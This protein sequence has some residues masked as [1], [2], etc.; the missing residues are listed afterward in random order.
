MK[1]NIFLAMIAAIVSINGICASYMTMGENDSLRIRPN[2]LNG[3]ST[4][5]VNMYLD[6]YADYFNVGISYPGG[7]RPKMMYNLRGIESGDG[8]A[9]TFTMYDGSEASFMPTLNVGETYQSVSASIS[10]TGWWD[11]NMDGVLEPYGSVKWEPGCH[12][13]VFVFNFWVNDD[14][15]EGYVVLDGV[16]NSGMDSR[17]PILANVQFYKKIW[18]WVG[19]MKG[20]VSGD[21]RV[22]ITDAT[23]LINSLQDAGDSIDDLDEFQLAAADINGDGIVNVTDVTELINILNN[24]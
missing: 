24:D 7:L 16:F 1:K 6:A 9:V 8:L 11:Y 12:E 15:R 13:E 10:T 4:Y 23:I 14:Y 2:R 5:P 22:N 18:C 21:E 20:D 17:G 3:Y 19:Y